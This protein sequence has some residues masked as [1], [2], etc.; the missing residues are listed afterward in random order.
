MMAKGAQSVRAHE[1][2]ALAIIN[3]AVAWEVAKKVE[4][5]ARAKKR[6]A[7]VQ[8]WEMGCAELVLGEE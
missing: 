1:R 8:A 5:M 6:C 7:R 2:P 4:N 3:V